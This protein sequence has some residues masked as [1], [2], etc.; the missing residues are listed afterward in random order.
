MD[1]GREVERMRAAL[2]RNEYPRLRMLLIVALTGGCGFLASF[3]MLHHGVESIALR[4]PLALCVAY[5]AF[6]LLLWAWLRSRP[7]DYL[8]APDAGS[9]GGDW[10]T[11]QHSGDGPGGADSFDGFDVGDDFAIP[12]LVIAF[13]AIVAC[14]SLWIVYSAPILF[15]ELLF[16]G[17]LAAGLYRRLRHS[18][19][20]HWLDTA[21]RRTWLPFALTAITL[22]AFGLGVQHVRPQARSIGD[23]LQASPAADTPPPR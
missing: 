8:D 12:L 6:L 14:A 21:L 4:Y 16:D 9:S 11:P 5:A 19:R 13:V 20:R 17:V 2:E 23:L 15:A 7:D 3:V 1:R 22:I 18:D 10:R